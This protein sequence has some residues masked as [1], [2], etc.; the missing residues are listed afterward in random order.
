[1]KSTSHDRRRTNSHVLSH[2]TVGRAVRHVPWPLVGIDGKPGD[3][4]VVEIDCLEGRRHL[5]IIRAK[6]AA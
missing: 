2:G 1:M 5:P 6:L 3:P 4:I